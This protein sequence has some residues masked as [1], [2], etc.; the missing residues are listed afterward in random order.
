MVNKPLGK[1]VDCG[2]GAYLDDPTWLTHGLV[3]PALSA[4][5]RL[6]G[7]STFFEQV[8]KAVVGAAG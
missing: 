7:E 6:H 5:D 2:R 3:E 1:G 4:V 8:Q